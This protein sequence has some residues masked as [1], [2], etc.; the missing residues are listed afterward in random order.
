MKSLFNLYFRK[1]K[2]LKKRL[3]LH[4]V[5]KKINKISIQTMIITYN[6][7]LACT[8]TICLVTHCAS[9]CAKQVTIARDTATCKV[10]EAIFATITLCPF[11]LVLAQ[12]L[13]TQCV[14][15]GCCGAKRVAVTG[16]TSLRVNSWQIVWAKLAF[17][18]MNTYLQKLHT[19]TSKN[20]YEW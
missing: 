2:R 13:T 15:V 6:I 7:P 11:H 12:T 20:L 16:C 4:N 3:W 10:K 19:S 8:L 14:T 1:K 17:I 9:L 5:I 18:T